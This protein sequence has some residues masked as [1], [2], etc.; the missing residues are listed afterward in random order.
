VRLVGE[1]SVPEDLELCNQYV[2]TRIYFHINNF[3]TTLFPR[4]FVELSS[5]TGIVMVTES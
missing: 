4:N 5:C 1:W 3:F 2:I